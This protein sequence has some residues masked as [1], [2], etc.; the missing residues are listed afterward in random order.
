[1]GAEPSK[2]PVAQPSQRPVSQLLSRPIAALVLLVISIVFASNH[3]AARFA[4]D[5]GANVLTAVT[6]RSAGTALVVAALIRMTGGSFA[7]TGT[8]PARALVIGLL[9]TVQSVCIYSAVA[10]IPVALAL[11][12]FNLFP[13]LFTLAHWGLNGVR[14]ANRM[15]VLFPIV[16]LGL[17]VALDA[18]GWSKGKTDFAGR[19]GEIGLGVSFALMA[20]LVFGF[21][22]A[23][24]ERW[25]GKVDGRLRSVLSMTVV[26]SVALAI[27]LAGEVG[28]IGGGGFALPHNATGWAGLLLLT[29]CYGSAFTV[30]FAL[31]PRLDMPR[32]AAIINFE[33]IAA[34]LIAWVLL[35]QAMAPL[36]IMGALIV[37][38]AIVYL[39]V[40]K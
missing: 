26:G 8:T 3:V 6:F 1:M 18:G 12:V 21:A 33:P 31:M 5:N 14:P 9:V 19:F 16:L 40:K 15:F 7:L 25:M 29:A 37:V 28:A 23:L 38:G 30:L 2:R 24:T 4:F 35:G 11:L 34:L 32:N 39:S 10:R 36:Q 13:L 20:A 27:G 22:L 17:T